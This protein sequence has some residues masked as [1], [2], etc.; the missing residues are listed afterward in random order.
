VDLGLTAG[1]ASAGAFRSV[2]ATLLSTGS[3]PERSTIAPEH[4]SVLPAGQNALLKSMYSVDPVTDAA[5]VK[6]PTLVV[7]GTQSTLV[8]PADA[9]RLAQVL[10]SAQTLS[11]DAT[12]TLQQVTPTPA[13]AFD[14]ADHRAHGGGRPSDT[15][16]R[17]Q[18]AI[19][20]IAQ[21]LRSKVPG[22]RL[23]WRP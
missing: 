18:A 19:D 7:T 11:V 6:I 15:A 13:Q 10:P 1:P 9:D 20:R 14:P 22:T 21:F 5:A 16:I 4:Q 12:A 3:L 2:V 8:G 23:A 17:D